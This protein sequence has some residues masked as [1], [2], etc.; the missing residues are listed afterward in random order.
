MQSDLP[1][2]IINSGATGGTLTLDSAANINIDG[3]IGASSAQP[4]V[5]GSVANP[6]A[7]NHQLV[8]K[9]VNNINVTKSIYLTGDLNFQAGGAVNIRNQAASAK[10]LVI[11]A[12]NISFGDSAHRV[13]SVNI[14]AL[15]DAN[16]A[17]QDRS[18]LVQSA[19][20][21]SV[22]T[23]G[24]FTL[25]GG[26]ASAS[27]ALAA[28]AIGG[29]NVTFDVGGT[30]GVYG[31]TAS[32]GGASSALVQATTAKAVVVGDNL[33]IKGG[34]VSGSGNAEAI[35]DPASPLSI[36]AGH[37]IVLQSGTGPSSGA[38]L[39]NAGA[40]NMQVNA[41]G[42]SP[43]TYGS[44]SYA[45]LV[46]IGPSGSGLV[47]I[48]PILGRY[49]YNLADGGLPPPITLTG[50]TYH[51]VL[52]G[53]LGGSSIIIANVPL[54]VNPDLAQQIRSTNIGTQVNGL[55]ETSKE[56]KLQDDGC[57]N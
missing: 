55:I 24:N 41:A 52:D 56:K 43:Y 17:G 30:L 3:Q 32:N 38:T 8:L 6:S 19:G 14:A 49:T 53:A 48:D 39:A 35:F 1:N 37:N 57:N 21:L 13:A 31:G 47:N 18:V 26:T 20:S 16:V 34:N 50:G 4:I 29:T 27:S 10:P 22:Y 12:A 44:G 25:Q 11:N 42:S 28:A 33:I 54:P 2:T 46:I 23:V 36:V 7:F 15:G 5:I 40:I 9:A 45:G 51:L